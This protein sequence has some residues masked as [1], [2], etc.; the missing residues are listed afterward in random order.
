MSYIRV[1]NGFQRRQVNNKGGLPFM[2]YLWL[3]WLEC[4]IVP[5]IP[6]SLGGLGQAVDVRVFHE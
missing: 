6:Y 2:I 5:Y 4:L 1:D 3:R